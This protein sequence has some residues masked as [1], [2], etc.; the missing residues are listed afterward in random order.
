MPA[1]GAQSLSLCLALPP[2]EDQDTVM[3]WDTLSACQ[4]P[5]GAADGTD[6]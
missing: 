4:M 2:P 3:H 1:T 5:A 6:L